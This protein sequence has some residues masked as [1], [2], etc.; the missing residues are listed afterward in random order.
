[1][2]FVF[3]LCIDRV[4]ASS[5]ACDIGKFVSDLSIPVISC[6]DVKQRQPAWQ[7]QQ[8]MNAAGW[9]AFRL[10]VNKNDSLKLLNTSKWRK[11]IIISDWFFKQKSDTIRHNYV[12]TQRHET[13]STQLSTVITSRIR[14]L[15]EVLSMAAMGS[16][17]SAT[18]TLLRQFGRSS[19]VT[20]K[21]RAQ[22]AVT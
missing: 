2:V 16:I 19:S 21:P 10:C 7:R 22:S 1:M 15:R 3:L 6:F 17:T 20:A 8:N 18:L 13:S 4:D 11:G 9:K 12:T 5:S 14:A